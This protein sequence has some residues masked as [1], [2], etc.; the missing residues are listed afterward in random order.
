MFEAIILTAVLGAAFGLILAFAGKYLYKETDPRVSA[1]SAL[2][3]GANCG[4]CGYPGCAAMAEHIVSGKA[5]RTACAVADAN[6]QKQI[7][8]I[9]NQKISETEPVYA[10]LAVLSC[11]GCA[12]NI[13]QSAVYHGPAD[14]RMAIKLLAAPGKCSYGCYGFGSCVQACP[15]GAITIGAHGLPQINTGKCTGCGMCVKTCPQHV[16]KLTPRDSALRLLCSNHDNA[17]TAMAACKASCIGCGL[18]VRTCPNGAITLKD[19]LPAIDYTKCTSCGLCT[20]KC[21]R[22][23]LVLAA[24]P[25]NSMP[26]NALPQN[27]GCAACP[28]AESCGIK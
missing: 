6:T 26:I 23:C 12:G 7:A 21:P 27:K 10:K 24:P 28:L 2:L 25:E 13:P 9:I 18:C 22:G 8:A 17:K 1:V 14:C 4:A 15:F 11:N 19:N 3:P 20:Q 5:D 16:L